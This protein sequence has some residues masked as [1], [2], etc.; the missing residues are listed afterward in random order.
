MSQ[1]VLSKYAIPGP[2]VQL[3]EVS[4]SEGELRLLDNISTEFFAHG[5][6]AVLGPNGGGKST[7]LKTILGLTAHQGTLQI[8]WPEQSECKL[9]Y[10]PQSMPFDASLPI[11]V[12]DYLLMSLSKKPI[13]FS[14]KL[15]AEIQAA[16][17]QVHL[18][19]KLDRRV[20]DLSGGERQR[21]MLATAL[22]KSPDLLILDEPMTGLD[23]SGQA[24]VL[25]ILSE[26]HQSGGTIIMVEHNWALVEQHC[27]QV[28][29]IDQQLKH[30][31]APADF[32]TNRPQD[33]QPRL[34]DIQPNL[35]ELNA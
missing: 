29:W 3:N 25:G 35:P 31:A 6:H 23:Q 24:D 5:W 7:L 26:Y 28:Y 21:L 32:F 10:L 8:L 9:G 11:S 16:I 22:L 2:S 27:D 18:T 1:T 14:R 17:Q 33:I 19:E 4:V 13:W 30:Q 34:E 12:R 15:P 20:G